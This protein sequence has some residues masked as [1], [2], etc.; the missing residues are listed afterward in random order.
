MSMTIPRVVDAW[1]LH[2]DFRCDLLE[3]VQDL[4]LVLL[5]VVVIQE[6]LV[7]VAEVDLVQE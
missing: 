6:V 2:L 7:V 5:L 4:V 1:P 3:C